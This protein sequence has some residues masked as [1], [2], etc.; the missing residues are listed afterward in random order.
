[1]VEFYIPDI[2]VLILFY[3]GWLLL[4]N[5]IPTYFNERLKGL[6]QKKDIG[7]L[8]TIVEGVKTQFQRET[9][10]INA[11]M[12]RFVN[13][14][15]SH[16]NEERNSII[17]FYGK[18]NQWLY[19]LMEINYASYNRK[20]IN[21]LIEK[22]T[23]IEKYYAET[24]VAQKK[25][26]LLVK[27][28]EIVVLSHSLMTIILD[29]KSWMAMRLLYL[30]Q[31]IESQI[32]LVDRFIPL[33]KKFDDNKTELKRLA[34]EETTLRTATKELVDYFY[35]NRNTEYSKTLITDATFTE[36]VKVYLT[37]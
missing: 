30:Q 37:K 9:D 20:S 26:K 34:E 13:L 18:Y 5:Y 33:M 3:V 2:I 14:E 11:S 29:F 25:L 1:M 19:A 23:Y 17:D 21:E 28:D 27:D 32:D 4:K 31:N 6:A 36:K 10:L 22:S 15:A 24:S 7:D 35:Q 8:T 12:Q 16:R